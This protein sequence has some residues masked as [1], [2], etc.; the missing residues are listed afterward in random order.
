MIFFLLLTC[1]KLIVNFQRKTGQTKTLFVLIGTKSVNCSRGT[2]LI[3]CRL[4]VSS[5]GV[6]IF[7]KM[8]LTSPITGASRL[9]STFAIRAI[10]AG[11]LR[12]F[13]HGR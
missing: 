5:L 6:R 11:S 12:V 8:I 10:S 7:R 2:T 3:R 1:Q 13:I 9:R 4:T